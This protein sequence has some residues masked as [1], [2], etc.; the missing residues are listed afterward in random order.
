MIS[1]LLAICVGFQEPVSHE[2]PLQ[3]SVTHDGAV[4]ES[5][6]GRLYIMLTRG[7]LPLIGGPNWFNPEPFLHLTLL[8]G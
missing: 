7:N 2:K 6:D 1:L 3:F 4:G 8:A 5:L